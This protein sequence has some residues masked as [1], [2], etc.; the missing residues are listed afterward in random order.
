MTERVEVVTVSS[1]VRS[2]LGSR[3]GSVDELGSGV[4]SIG[5]AGPG[6]GEAGRDDIGTPRISAK[7]AGEDEAKRFDCRCLCRELRLA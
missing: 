5:V 7:A 3:V 2:V 4:A 1:A 6:D